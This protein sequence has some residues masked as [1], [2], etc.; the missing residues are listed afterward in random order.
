MYFV[1][2]IAKIL[3]LGLL[4]WTI[5]SWSDSIVTISQLLFKLVKFFFSSLVSF[6][7]KD[8]TVEPLLNKEL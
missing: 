8:T 3:L 2:I 4:L 7:N 1:D 6:A 5:F